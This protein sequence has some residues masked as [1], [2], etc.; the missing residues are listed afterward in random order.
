M[1]PDSSLRPM[2]AGGRFRTVAGMNTFLEFL[3]GT[4]LV[5]AASLVVLMLVG[6][7]L[8]AVLEWIRPQGPLTGRSAR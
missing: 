5:V 8:T 2:R 1:M 4:G 6:G 7:A 3:V